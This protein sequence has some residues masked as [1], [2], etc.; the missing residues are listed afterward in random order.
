MWVT[1]FLISLTTDQRLF[2][3]EHDVLDPQ[4]MAT[5]ADNYA[6][7]HRSYPGDSRVKHFDKPIGKVAEKAEVQKSEK[8]ELGLR[9]CFS[10]GST[11]HLRNKCPKNPASQLNGQC[12]NMNG[13][14]APTG[15]GTINGSKVSTIL[16][17]TGCT[18]VLVSEEVLPNI[19]PDDYPKS[20]NRDY[21]GRCD[22]FPIVRCYLDCKWYKGW[23]DAV[24]APIKY[25]SVMLGNIPGAKFPTEFECTNID[26]EG[27]SSVK[28]NAVTRAQSKKKGTIHPLILPSVQPLDISHDKFR[29]LQS[30]CPT[31][32]SIRRKCTENVTETNKAGTVFKYVM[33]NSLI[34]RSI[35]N[36]KNLSDIGKK[37]L[38]IPNE[39]KVVVLKLSHDLPVSGHFSHRKTLMKVRTNF[40]WPNMTVDVL[41]YC[42]SCDLCQKNVSK[43]RVK[44]APLMKMPIVSVHLNV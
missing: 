8:I 34:Y 25:C 30:N 20:Q 10:C 6:T 23:V 37:V 9:K 35:I 7:A 40:Y 17:D 18:G 26:H 16:R 13:R 39:C 31:L 3:K 15:N 14:R 41:K 36:S 12:L 4:K 38:V 2:V 27:L 32:E 1:N 22:I 33:H 29:E 11:G 43:G 19:N 28:V 42:R 5:L 44:A 21:L 24:R